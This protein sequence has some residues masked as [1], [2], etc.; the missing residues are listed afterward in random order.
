MASRSGS[1]DPG[2]LLWL[3]A[4]GGLS[5]NELSDGLEHRSGPTGLARTPDMRAVLAHAAEGDDDAGPAMDVYVHR[6]RAGIA[7][8]DGLDALV[9]HRWCGRGRTDRARSGLWRARSSGRGGRRGPQRGRGR[10]HRYPC[11]KLA[12]WCA[13]DHGLRGPRDC[14]PGRDD[15]RARPVTGSLDVMGRAEHAAGWTGRG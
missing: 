5:L 10:R 2:I 7:A 14:R 3:Q 12:R 13:R 9:V 15:P 8:M 6:L 1:V 11:S 4:E